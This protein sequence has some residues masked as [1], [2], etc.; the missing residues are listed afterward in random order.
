M[1]IV[2]ETPNKAT[3]IDMADLLLGH[4]PKFFG[5]GSRFGGGI[6]TRYIKLREIKTAKAFPHNV[7]I[8]FEMP[9]GSTG[10]LKTLHFSISE[11][12]DHTG[13]TPRK[14]DDRVGYFTTAFDDLGKFKK[15]ETRTRYINRW[16]LE[17]AD[18]SLKF[19]PPKQ[20]IIFYV[21][22]STPIRYRRFV[23]DG[24]L[25]WNKAFEKVGLV[26]AIE[27][28]FQDARTGTHMEKDPEDVR[29]NFVR[30]LSN[31][32]GTAIGPSRVHPLTGEDPRC[33]HHPDRRLD[34]PFRTAVR[35]VAAAAGH[36]RIRPRNA[37][38]ARTQAALGSAFP[39]DAGRSEQP[40]PGR[41]G[42]TRR[43]APG[44]PSGGP[45]SPARSWARTNSTG[46]RAG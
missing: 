24:V 10:Q 35:R 8:A 19:S 12:P 20:P 41:A 5:F 26:N 46:C 17:K 22:H 15:D 33:G 34:S 16:H 11:M 14:A 21:E 43:S 42:Q 40:V 23:K 27:V 9:F 45:T 38:L 2:A 39:A 32:Q 25:Y 36:G 18:P 3:V 31:N 44:R 13:Y 4:A 29:Y 6:D 1:P 28:Y 7:E 30:W 37:D